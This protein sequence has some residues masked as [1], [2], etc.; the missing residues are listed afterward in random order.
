MTSL[1]HLLLQKT[2]TLC[3][4]SSSSSSSSS[5]GRKK[6]RKRK[7]RKSSSSSSTT[8]SSSSSEEEKEIKKK[9]KAA[10]KNLNNKEAQKSKPLSQ[11]YADLYL[12]KLQKFFRANLNIWDFL[13]TWNN[14]IDHLKRNKKYVL[15]EKYNWCVFWWKSIYFLFS[16][17]RDWPVVDVITLFLLEIRKI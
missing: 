15:H 16:R 13:L 2:S 6:K 11:F 7:T 8:S 12:L 4:F 10:A 17:N 1:A 3:F 14:E 9:K 5:D